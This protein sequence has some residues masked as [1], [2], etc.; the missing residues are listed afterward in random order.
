M[1]EK[2]IYVR[3]QPKRVRLR[4]TYSYNQEISR[5]P[6]VR[7]EQMPTGQIEVVTPYDG[8]HYFTRQACRDVEVQ[9]GDG[10]LSEGVDALIGHLALNGYGRTD[11]ENVLSLNSRYGSVPLRIPVS[12]G[13]LAGMSDLC[14]DRH[15]C[16]IKFDYAP[17]LPEWTPVDI[18]MELLDED[19][20]ELPDFAS[21][22]MKAVAMSETSVAQIAQQVSFRR[23]LLLM[24]RVRLH[25]DSDLASKELSPKVTRVSIGWPTVTS[26]RKLHFRAGDTTPEHEMRITYDPATRSLRLPGVKMETSERSLSNNLQ[27]YVSQSMFLLVDQPGELYQ[28]DSLDGQVEVEVPGGLLSGVQARVYDGNGRLQPESAVKSSTRIVVNY[29]L[30]LDDAF[31]RR[32]RSPYQ[33]LHFSGVI[34]EPMRVMDI[35][36]ALADRGFRIREEE[37]VRFSDNPL[38][39]FIV[40]RRPEGPD[41]MQLWVLVEGKRFQAERQTQL[42]GDHLYKKIVESGELKLY[43][44]GQLP[45]DSS[46][47]IQEM[48]AL[49]LA[50]R[51]RFVPSAG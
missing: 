22:Q 51:D 5:N 36:T 3:A 44:R 16:V 12:G 2:V 6:F 39:H 32:T 50:L 17:E 15:A 14:D 19:M 10:P 29:K 42:P 7:T 40:A 20:F 30:I 34:P 9:T 24:I 31:S 4:E 27:T 21:P 49:Q 18:E 47:I 8:S 1:T 23:N 35:E 13:A 48:N 11:L 41:T 26:F 45:G 33:H 37:S 38:K 43:I 28:Q 46:K 25:L